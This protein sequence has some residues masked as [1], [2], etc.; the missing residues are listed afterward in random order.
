MGIGETLRRSLAKLVMRAAGDQAKTVCGNIQLCA[1]L[2]A[3]IEGS[4]HAIGKW[5]MERSREIQRDQEA[6]T[7]DEKEVLGNIIIETAG[8][9][10]EVTEGLEA[11]LGMDIE[12]VGTFMVKDRKGL[13]VIIGHWEP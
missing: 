6:Q 10:E 3:I 11:A 4:T 7:S 13:K 12:E 9:E 5:R 8:T 2:K 1:G